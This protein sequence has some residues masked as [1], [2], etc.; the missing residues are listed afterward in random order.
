MSFC[1]NLEQGAPLGEHK[2]KEISWNQYKVIYKPNTGT[3]DYSGY[4]DTS[5]H[6][7]NNA[8]EYEGQTVTPVTHL[9]ENNYTKKDMCL[10]DGIRNQT[11][12]E[13][14]FR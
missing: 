6:M 8:T 3:D 11:V 1:N 14:L 9:T 13:S 2:C 7:Y 12:R 10:S 4:M 5:Y